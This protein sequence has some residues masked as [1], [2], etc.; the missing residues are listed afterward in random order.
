MVYSIYKKFTCD[1]MEFVIR[2]PQVV[3]QE[4]NIEKA[5]MK[6]S[7]EKDLLETTNTS[8]SSENQ[9]EEKKGRI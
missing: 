7:D 8:N 1:T 2:Y 4:E 3:F 6:M 5:G 9:E